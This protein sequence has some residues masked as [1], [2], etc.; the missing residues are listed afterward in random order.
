M[1]IQEIRDRFYAEWNRARTGND[2]YEIENVGVRHIVNGEDVTDVIAQEKAEA[3]GILLAR[4]EHFD[5]L[6]TAAG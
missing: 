1:T 6:A 2:A 4:F 3:C 5:R